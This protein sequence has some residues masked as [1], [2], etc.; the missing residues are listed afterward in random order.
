MDGALAD[1][2]GLNESAPGGIFVEGLG[3]FPQE[4]FRF[5][6]NPDLPRLDARPFSRG[7][8][9]VDGTEHA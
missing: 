8:Q 2:G 9:N 5:G 6:P 1:H 7:R 4:A 3:S